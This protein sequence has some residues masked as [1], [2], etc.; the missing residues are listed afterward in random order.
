LLVMPQALRPLTFNEILDRAFSLYRREFSLFVGISCVL[1]MPLGLLS[2]TLI[3]TQGKPGPEAYATPSAGLMV[4]AV[5]MV[6]VV[7][8][9]TASL[10]LQ[11]CLA[12]AIA[13]RYLERP[14]TVGQA[15]A[16]TV[17]RAPTLIATFFLM[18]LVIMGGFMLCVV[19][20]LVFMVALL[21]APQIAML[22]GGDAMGSIRRSRALTKGDR[23]RIFGMFLLLGVITAVLEWGAR[24]GVN[25][26]AHSKLASDLAAQ[27][28]ATIVAPITN[29]ALVL[30]YF[31]NRVRKEGYDIALMAAELAGRQASA[32]AVA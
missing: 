24:F 3:S 31:D 7:L 23:W 28:I 20:G 2:T 6:A 4:F 25:L 18:E 1:Y 15:L 27:V 30:L 22:E 26:I 19:P 32:P 29:I 9:L 14:I 8:I 21:L 13:E 16:R 11:G 17:R 12:V 5:S 10:L